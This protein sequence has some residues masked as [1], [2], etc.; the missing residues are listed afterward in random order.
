M[1]RSRVLCM[2]MRQVLVQVR[3]QLQ[4]QSRL[5]YRLLKQQRAVDEDGLADLKYGLVDSQELAVDTNGKMLL[6]TG[7]GVSASSS[8]T[9]SLHSPPPASNTPQ[10]LVARILAEPGSGDE[11]GA[12]VSGSAAALLS[13]AVLLPRPRDAGCAG[14]TGIP[15]NSAQNH[16]H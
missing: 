12:G 11:R 8:H 6:W 4:Q 5:S 1:Q 2:A 7:E 16:S 3:A 15:Q 13:G 9:R 10:H 14:R